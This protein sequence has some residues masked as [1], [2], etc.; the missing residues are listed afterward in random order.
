MAAKMSPALKMYHLKG[1]G[2]KKDLDQIHTTT[3]TFKVAS[4][5]SL[6]FKI[7]GNEF[8]IQQTVSHSKKDK[9]SKDP[10]IWCTETL[11]PGSPR[12]VCDSLMSTKHRMAWDATLAAHR[13]IFIDEAFPDIF[14][15]HSSAKAAVG[16]L[17]SSRDFV[18]LITVQEFKNEATGYQSLQITSKSIEREDIPEQKGSIRGVIVICGVLIERLSE[19]EIEKMELPNLM[20][21]ANGDENADKVECEWTRMK[22]IIQADLKGW[23]PQTAINAGMSQ[24]NNDLMNN[25][26]NY[27]IHNRWGL[28][29]DDQ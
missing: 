18:D 7:Q 6:K 21:P 14:I 17:I 1:I 25:L 23:L 27:I 15:L 19:E 24:S 4:D 12:F 9:E 10:M 28:T 11:C 5:M 20:V 8:K 16:G 29:S 26:R 22:Y 2:I 13:Q 3:N